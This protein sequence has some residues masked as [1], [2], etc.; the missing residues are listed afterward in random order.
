MSEGGIDISNSSRNWAK[1]TISYLTKNKQV[2]GGKGNTLHQKR[3]TGIWESP[4]KSELTC[5]TEA[6]WFE[7]KMFV[8]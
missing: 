4:N 7:V 6:T 8:F 3:K 2:S 1:V 5:E